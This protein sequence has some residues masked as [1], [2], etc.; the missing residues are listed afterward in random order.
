MDSIA[1]YSDAADDE[2]DIDDEY[3]RLYSSWCYPKLLHQLQAF[4]RHHQTAFNINKRP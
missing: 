2:H 1:D 4:W 3:D